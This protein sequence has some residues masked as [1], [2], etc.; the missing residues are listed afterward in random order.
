[1][2]RTDS[3]RGSLAESDLDDEGRAAELRS[4]AAVSA[5]L[6]D[7]STPGASP[8]SAG[9]N[10]FDPAG[11]VSQVDAQQL[12]RQLAEYER[13]QTKLSSKLRASEAENTR[14]RLLVRH[15]EHRLEAITEPK[16]V[17]VIPSE[18][19]AY[20]FSWLN[21]KGLRICLRTCRTWR[22]TII[23]SPSVGSLLRQKILVIGGSDGARRHDNVEQF[24]MFTERWS[25]L[26][27][28]SQDFKP[29]SNCAQAQREL[30]MQLRQAKGAMAAVQSG[31][32]IYIIGGFNSIALK[33]CEVFNLRTRTWRDL[34]PMKIERSKAAAVLIG[35]DVYVM[36]GYNGAAP[37]SSVERFDLEL[38]QWFEA[39]DMIEH[40]G[41]H[42]AVELG[43][44]IFVFGGW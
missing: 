1:M 41:A 2:Q 37:L 4:S 40:R 34:P 3:T 18:L 7:V 42:A 29:A 26:L 24:D 31:H 11:D 27:G 19:F 28:P 22:R 32:N 21:L 44:E 30:Q 33:Q 15:L 14:L 13:S 23:D 9:P 20:I 35:K 16:A 17:K 8:V 12:L 38:E 39:P 5:A 43:G 36:G 25:T 10:H 6:P